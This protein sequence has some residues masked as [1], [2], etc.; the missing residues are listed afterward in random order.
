MSIR[1]PGSFNTI[2]PILTRNLSDSG[3]QIF[4]ESPDQLV[5]SDLN[6]AA[7]CAKFFNKIGEEIF[8]CLDVYEWEADGAG[9]CRSESQNGGC[10]FLLSTGAS[11]EPSYLADASAS[12][13]DV[14]IYTGQPLVSQD[15]DQL[16][17]LYDV[18]V[19]G[20]IGAQNPPSVTPC[21]GEGCKEGA[22]QSSPA[23]P[24]GSSTF[25]G[26]PNPKPKPCK[27]GLVRKGQKCVKK[28]HKKTHHKK[29]SRK[30]NHGSADR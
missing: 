9:T 4:F 29:K 15:K 13:D 1:P 16:V 6:S 10:L 27:K 12:G 18:R 22:K 7:G 8:P 30:Q 2:F 5:T 28:H 21:L 3:D 19:G 26:P 17:D 24:P 14:F 11:S 20:G 23:S 25:S